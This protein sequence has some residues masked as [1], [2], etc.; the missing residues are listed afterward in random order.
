MSVDFDSFRDVLKHPIRRKIVLALNERKNLTYTDLMSYAESESTGKIN[1][2]LK[3]LGDLITKNSNGQYALTEKGVLAAQFLLTFPEKKKEP[4]SLRMVDATLIGLFGVVLTVANPLFWWASF[5]S[6]QNLT[7]A[8]SVL[9]VFGYSNFLYGLFVPSLAMWI[10]T[11]RRARSHDMYDL[12]KPA[13]VVFVLLSA[14]LALMFLANINIT[15]ELYTES[16][17]ISKYGYSHSMIPL[18]LAGQ[19]ISGIIY[20]FLGIALIEGI[21]RIRKKLALKQ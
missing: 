5:V 2:H 12:F 20:A 21:A 3:A 18:N 11:I 16:V 10:L 9:P 17:P 15:G 1:Y 13:L 7:V 19:L 4:S 8:P 14:F 6:L